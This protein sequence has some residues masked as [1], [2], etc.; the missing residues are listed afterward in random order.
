MRAC[1]DAV[2]VF[3]YI[4]LFFCSVSLSVGI[5]WC[6][7]SLVHGFLFLVLVNG[8]QLAGGLLS[9]TICPGF[10]LVQVLQ[11]SVIC[12]SRAGWRDV[13]CNYGLQRRLSVG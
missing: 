1:G 12:T 13:L 11:N 3:F 10:L 9:I 5:K 7:A 8:Q 4:F 6:F 2:V